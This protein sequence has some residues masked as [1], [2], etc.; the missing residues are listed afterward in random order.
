MQWLC[1]AYIELAAYKDA[2]LNYNNAI[3][4][5]IEAKKQ[6]NNS[7]WTSLLF[8]KIYYE[9][10]KYDEAIGYVNEAINNSNSK[11]LMLI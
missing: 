10:E 1:A 7:V 4:N 5:C 3:S 9:Q 6:E 11:I 2:S 8:S